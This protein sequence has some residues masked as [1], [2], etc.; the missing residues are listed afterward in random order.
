MR[1]FTEKGLSVPEALDLQMVQKIVTAGGE[2]LWLDLNDDNPQ[3]NRKIMEETFHFHPLAIDD[4][5]LETHIPKI[6]DWGEYLYLALEGAPIGQT[7]D[8][9]NKSLELDIF[10]G[11]S[12]LVT[13]HPEP[14]STIEVVWKNCQRDARLDWYARFLCRHDNHAGFAFGHVPVDAQARLDVAF[15]IKGDS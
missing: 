10:I 1:I 7:L 2:L 6:D 12:Y 14:I 5:L 8:D 11:K 15:Y 3:T 9:I 4:A 13:C